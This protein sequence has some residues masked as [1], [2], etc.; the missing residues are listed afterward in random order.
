MVKL[1]VSSGNDTG[2]IKSYMAV[3][4]VR[5]AHLDEVDVDADEL[6]EDGV[7]SPL[8]SEATEK[9]KLRRKESVMRVEKEK[10]QAVL[11]EDYDKA[12]RK[13]LPRQA[14]LNPPSFEANLRNPIRT[15]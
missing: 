2:R 7:M 1:C 4:I 8:K 3:D 5:M 12:V 14:Q 13:E 9:K 10:A 6:S 11:N 15:S